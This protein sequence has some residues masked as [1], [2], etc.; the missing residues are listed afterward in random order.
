MDLFLFARPQ[1]PRGRGS[2]LEFPLERSGELEGR[3]C[4]RRDAF[5]LGHQFAHDRS[6]LLLVQ[7]ISEY[8]EKVLVNGVQPP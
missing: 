3:G 7:H 2:L 5:A 4:E 8:C 6:K 1:V